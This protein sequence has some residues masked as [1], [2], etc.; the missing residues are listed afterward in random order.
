MPETASRLR[1]RLALT[2][3]CR[4]LHARRGEARIKATTAVETAKATA[5]KATRAA[6]TTVRTTAITKTTTATT[7]CASFYRFLGLSHKTLMASLQ[8]SLSLLLS[9]SLSPA[10]CQLSHIL[11]LI[12]SIELLL[13]FLLLLQLLLHWLSLSSSRHFYCHL[14]RCHRVAAACLPFF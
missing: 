12:F 14:F 5:T 4:K 3:A 6:T 10:C 11:P 9:F 8:P 1:L 2:L 7:T 13:L